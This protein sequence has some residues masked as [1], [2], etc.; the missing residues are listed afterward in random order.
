MAKK[1]DENLQ[2]NAAGK[3]ALNHLLEDMLTFISA[4]KVNQNLQKLNAAMIAELEQLAQ[5]FSEMKAKIAHSGE[6]SPQEL[7]KISQ[8]LNRAQNR[9]NTYK[10][11]DS[12]TKMLN[13]VGRAVL[14]EAKKPEDRPDQQR[15]TE[16]QENIKKTVE[17]IQKQAAI[18]R[19]N[20]APKHRSAWE[21]FT[22][23]CV[24]FARTC[25]D[26]ILSLFGKLKTKTPEQ[27]TVSAKQAVDSSIRKDHLQ[28]ASA[29]AAEARKRAAAK[30]QSSDQSAAPVRPER[31]PRPT[32]K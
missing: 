32:R 4:M 26:K 21:K 9:I 17:Q 18:V 13:K 30:A 25:R 3:T 1:T 7:L 16:M 15:M 14:P 31:P 22:R 8:D 20:A 19:A 24:N 10:F 28:F 5:Q 12:T 27:P 29:A 11:E 2:L 6:I 23:A